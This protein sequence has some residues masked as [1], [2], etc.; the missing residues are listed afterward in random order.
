MKPLITF[1]IIILFTWFS[2]PIKNLELPACEPGDHVVKH[3]GYTLGY[4]NH[5]KQAAW[6]AYVLTEKETIKAIERGNN[7]RPDPDVPAGTAD[8]IDYKGSGYDRGHLA[9]AA[10]MGWCKTAMQESFY[11]SNMSPQEPGFNRGIWKRLEELVRNWA[12]EYDSIC[13]VTGPILTP[14]LPKIGI[15]NV[16]VPK[17]YYKVILDYTGDEVKGIGFILPNS[18]SSAPLSS[19][20]LPI[21]NVETIT[22]IDFFPRLPDDQEESIESSCII[23]AWK[24]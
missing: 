2:E 3:T 9:P 14:D 16:S 4:N 12:I 6:V 5:H 20:A 8:D 13:I 21:N 11:Y 17:H 7:F 22:N 19:F 23:S 15:H 10:D 1:L 18:S 24:W